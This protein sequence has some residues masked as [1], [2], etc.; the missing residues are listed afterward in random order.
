MTVEPDGQL[1]VIAAEV[2]GMSSCASMTARAAGS[3]NDLYLFMAFHSLVEIC[4]DLI[5]S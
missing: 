3:I 2:G 5:C 4:I 1:W